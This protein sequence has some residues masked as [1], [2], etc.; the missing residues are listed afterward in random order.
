MCNISTSSTTSLNTFNNKQQQLQYSPHQSLEQF[1]L[2]T[3]KKGGLFFSKKISTNDLMAWTKDPIQKPLIKTNDK[4]V[5][6]EAPEL[7]KLIQIYMSDRRSGVKNLDLKQI[8]L[9]IMIKGWSM[10]VLRDELFFQLLKQTNFNNNNQS[11][12]MGWELI[13]ISLSF[14][15]PSQKLYPYFYEYIQRFTDE[16]FD[17][18]NL[19]I[20]IFARACMKRLERI[21][22][23][24]AKKGIKKPTLD[25]IELSKVCWWLGRGYIYKFFNFPFF[26]KNTITCVSLFGT[27]LNEIMTI[28]NSTCPSLRLPWIQTTLSE[29]VLRLNGSKTEGIFR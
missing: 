18:E 7:F 17:Q 19:E 26:F 13:A 23:T 24:G 9:D 11:L 3:H 4:T 28:Q 25:E 27:T 8:C 6:K 5:K 1:D 20:S 29:A 22:S 14:F 12:K 15:P 10:S 16:S 21:H 2:N